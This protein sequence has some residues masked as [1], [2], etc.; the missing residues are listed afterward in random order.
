[1]NAG[2]YLR[3]SLTDLERKLPQH[4]PQP[5]GE[6]PTGFEWLSDDELERAEH[7]L[8]LVGGDHPEALVAEAEFLHLLAQ[9]EARR[10]RGEPTVNERHLAT[11][12]P[13]R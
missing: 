4:P 6:E 9:G 2:A 12:P 5:D 13:G 8:D 7:L 10:A 11:F 3:R 1:V